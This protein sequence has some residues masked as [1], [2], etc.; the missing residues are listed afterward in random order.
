MFKLKVKV[1]KTTIKKL[2]DP[3]P[4]LTYGYYLD[5]YNG[6]DGYITKSDY[7]KLK[8]RFFPGSSGGSA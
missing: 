1:N 3:Y 6:E 8:K 2:D 5:Q 7:E 4:N